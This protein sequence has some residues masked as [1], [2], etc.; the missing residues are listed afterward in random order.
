LGAVCFILFYLQ[1]TEAK[2]LKT[3]LTC[4]IFCLTVILFLLTGTLA[5]QSPAEI[6]ITG[7]FQNQPIADFF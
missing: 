5:A 4:N 7:N 3:E 1:K 2:V 6:K